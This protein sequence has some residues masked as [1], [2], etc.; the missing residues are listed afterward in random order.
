MNDAE[1]FNV[2]LYEK[3]KAEQDK[4]RDWLTEQL[5]AEILSHAYEYSMREDIVICIE[6]MEL[7]PNQVKSLLKSPCPLSDIYDEF[8]ERET[9]HMDIIRD[10]IETEADKGIRKDRQKQNRESR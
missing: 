8:Q 3:M 2:Q 9:D 5:P 1:N 10:C 4:Y 6:N 7:S